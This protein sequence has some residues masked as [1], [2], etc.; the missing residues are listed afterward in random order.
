MAT[1][2][3]QYPAPKFQNQEE[4]DKYWQTHSPLAEG[5]EGKAQYKK[6]N[7]ASF[8]SIRL[9]GEELAHLREAAAFR[10]LTPS[11]YARQ[12]IIDGIEAPNKQGISPSDIS[13][14]DLTDE[15]LA[16]ILNDVS[17]VSSQLNRCI[18]I[19]MRSRRPKQKT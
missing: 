8:L 15:E 17:N 19:L 14:A 10:R 1:M 2:K 11:T 4:E 16:D 6:Q 7:R 9:T 12:L 5:Y 13:I 18:R 3:K